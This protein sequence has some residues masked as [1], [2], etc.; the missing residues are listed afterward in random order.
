MRGVGAAVA[1]MAVMT[2]LTGCGAG[3]GTSDGTAGL[4]TASAREAGKTAGEELT[5]GTVRDDFRS[6]ASAAG[7][8]RL[9]FLDLG[10]HGQPCRVWGMSQTEDMVE[11]EAVEPVLTVLRD[12]GWRVRSELPVEESGSFGWVLEKNRWE[13]FLAAGEVPEGAGIVFDASGTACGAPMPAKP[14]TLEPP[15]RPTPPAPQ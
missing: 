8:G 9:R 14:S 12:R 11:R 3:D 15:Q 7:A 5:V 2:V 10:E 13:V 4:S 6:A 1:A